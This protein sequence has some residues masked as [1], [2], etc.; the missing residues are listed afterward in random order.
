VKPSPWDRIYNQ[1]T[2][3]SSAA[4]NPPAKVDSRPANDA[5]A[6]SVIIEP[7]PTR[8]I[9][10]GGIDDIRALYRAA[11]EA[12]GQGDYATAVKKYEQIKEFSKDLWPRDLD[13]RLKAARDQL[14]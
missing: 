9:R 4:P 1:S 13:L 11:I 14:H 2:T 10:D 3:G 8:P 7:P 5:A 12:D 6:P